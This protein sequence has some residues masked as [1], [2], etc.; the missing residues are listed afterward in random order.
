[1]WQAVKFPSILPNCMGVNADGLNGLGTN[2]PLLSSAEVEQITAE[3]TALLEE[4]VNN[5]TSSV[6]T[7]L[8]ETEVVLELQP[9]ISALFGVASTNIGLTIDTT[10]AQLLGEGDELDTDA[11]TVAGEIN[12]AGI[13]LD[14]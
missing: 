3:V 14:A 1:M 8:E 12:I 2:T 11:L 10:L 6:Q 13:E 5:V 7:L 9:E 4:L